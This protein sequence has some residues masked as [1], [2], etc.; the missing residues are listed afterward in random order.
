M[1]TVKVRPNRQV[2]IPE[3]IFRRLKL[4]DGDLLKIDILDDAAITLIPKN[5]IPKGQRWFWTPTWQRW[6]REALQDVKRGRV[7]S[8]DN[9]D[10]LLNDLRS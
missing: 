2:T 4:K 1:P 6:Y 10:D 8:F 9:I 3:T 5:R 7:K